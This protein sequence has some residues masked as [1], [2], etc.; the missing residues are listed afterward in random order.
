MPAGAVQAPRTRAIDGRLMARGRW[1][2]QVRVIRPKHDRSEIFSESRQRLP[3]ERQPQPHQLTAYA[4]QRA[5]LAP[6]ERELRA[7]GHGKL[8]SAY[9][10]P[11]GLRPAAERLR[12][13]AENL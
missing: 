11:K 4:R 13:P 7:Q 1:A 2:E 3:Q 8:P 6:R 10:E 5:V 9:V 12:P